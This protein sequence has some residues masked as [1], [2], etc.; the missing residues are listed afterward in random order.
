MRSRR[1]YSIYVL[2][3]A[4]PLLTYRFS[5]PWRSNSSD[6]DTSAAVA[7][8]LR[9][10][11]DARAGDGSLD[12]VEDPRGPPS[13]ET[14]PNEGGAAPPPFP[15]EYHFVSRSPELSKY[16]TGPEMMALIKVS[17]STEQE[18]DSHGNRNSSGSRVIDNN[19]SSNSNGT[20][21]VSSSPSSKAKGNANT[22][23][24]TK[25]AEGDPLS[26]IIARI[27]GG[28]SGGGASRCAG[29]DVSVLADSMM[30]CGAPLSSPCFDR[31]RCKPRG[32]GGPGPSM[33]VYDAT[34]SLA[35][36]SALPPSGESLMLSHAWREA[37]RE[38]G[39]LSETYRDAC[40]FVHVNK[41]V[42]R[43]PCA[44]TSPLWN[45]GANHLMVDLTD[46]TR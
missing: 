26:A 5:A 42:D 21:G 22:N 33:Y 32:L 4:L 1:R 35:D 27:G 11:E 2:C 44:S 37:A 7:V 10:R 38:A 31:D 34:C 12:D 36:S 17:S 43:P 39:V 40:I 29:I 9:T 45:G 41:L 25:A 8:D 18:A 15:A 6:G 30:A 19:N 20:G 24:N 14:E 3:I 46:R 16:L 23:T 28:G 13:A